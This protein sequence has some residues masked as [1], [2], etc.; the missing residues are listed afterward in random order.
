MR[1]AIVLVLVA[2]VCVA[3]SRPEGEEDGKKPGNP[4]EPFIDMAKN[5]MKHMP[6]SKIMEKMFG[7]GNKD[8]SEGAPPPP[9]E[10]RR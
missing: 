6:G 8:K 9:E 4:F 2:L 10:D 5:A 3:H 7:G 1:L